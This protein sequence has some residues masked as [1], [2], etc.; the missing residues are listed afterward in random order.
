MVRRIWGAVGIAFIVLCLSALP[1]RAVADGRYSY[2]K[3]AN[4]TDWCV[5]WTTWA[6]DTLTFDVPRWV[7]IH[8]QNVPPH[9]QAT[10]GSREIEKRAS[11]PTD[12]NLNFGA[13][14]QLQYRGG[15]DFLFYWGPDPVEGRV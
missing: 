12:A 1:S 10:V 7:W 6:A 4:N 13:T 11:Q 9:K 15:A 2:I 3:F 5:W 14:E 8:A